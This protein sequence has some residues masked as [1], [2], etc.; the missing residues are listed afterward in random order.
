[1]RAMPISAALLAAALPLAAN[2]RAQVLPAGR[3]RARDGRPGPGQW[4][5]LNDAQGQALADA[6]NAIAR[7]TPISIDYEH[8]TLL[9]ATNGQPAPSAGHMLAFEWHAGEG[10]FAQVEWT[11]RARAHIAAKEYLWLSPVVLVN[12]QGVIT[13][14]HNAALVSTPALL[15]MDPVQAALSALA[16]SPSPVAQPSATKG[17][18]VT[19]LAS[20]LAALGLPAQ[21]AEVD[22]LGAVTAL[23]AKADAPPP[24]APLPTAL[25]AALGLAATADEAA[26]LS[27][28]ATLRQ[29]Q[30]DVIVA[31]QTQVNTLQAR[32]VDTELATL[33]DAALAERRILPANVE[34]YRGMGRKDMAQLKAVLAT[35][36]PVAGTAGTQTGGVPPSGAPGAG[37]AGSA[38]A[39]SAQQHAIATR[40]GLDPAKYAEALKANTQPA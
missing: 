1:M 22:A 17:S 31:L 12:G 40:L 36:H 23:R 11:Q 37:A 39:L 24:K 35:L 20:L 28:V 30:S 38:A 27:A 25:T 16:S 8:Q 34:L 3:F 14:I 26:A 18:D 6:L 10:L 5:Q 7:Q 29:G 15:G 19:L 33:I 2:G 21:T 13:G 32:V 4:W 9:A